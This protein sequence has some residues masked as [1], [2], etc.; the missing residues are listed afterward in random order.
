MNTV[1]PAV[2]NRLPFGPGTTPVAGLLPSVP[3]VKVCRMVSV[4][5]FA[6]LEGGSSSKTNPAPLSPPPS[7]VPYS[8]P[9]GPNRSGPTGIVPSVP[10]K[11]KITVEVLTAQIVISSLAC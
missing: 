2:P 11:E 4:H 9:F 8:T 6:G 5:G 1:P 7:A 10:L 3:P